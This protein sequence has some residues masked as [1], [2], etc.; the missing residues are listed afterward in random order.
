MKKYTLAL[1]LLLCALGAT[2]ANAENKDLPNFHKVNVNLYRGGRPTDAGVRQLVKLKIQTDINLENDTRA[3]SR[4]RNLAKSLG[5]IF[6]SHPMDAYK[7]PDDSDVMDVLSTLKDDSAFPIFIHCHY[8]M[9]RTG[10]LV[11]LYRV[12]IDHWSPARAYQEMLDIGFH[13]DLDQLDRYFRDKT[14]YDGE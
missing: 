8:G 11:G 1:V 14:G 6:D 4:E 12:K 5:L 3:A 13:P 9:D 7:Y 10:L 2:V